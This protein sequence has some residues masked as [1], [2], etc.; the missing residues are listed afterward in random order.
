MGSEMCI[1]DRARSSRRWMSMAAMT[2]DASPG[3]CLRQPDRHGT[4][5]RR[6]FYNDRV[7]GLF[8][9]SEYDYLLY[10]IVGIIRESLLLSTRAS[11]ERPLWVDLTRSQLASGMVGPVA[12][13]ARS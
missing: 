7:F 2:A 6:P 3:G 12:H 1:R 11:V 4:L 5:M 13:T 8:C 10:P 9:W